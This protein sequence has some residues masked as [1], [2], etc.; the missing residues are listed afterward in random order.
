VPRA[1]APPGAPFPVRKT[2]GTQPVQK[3]R[4]AQSQVAQWES[5]SDDVDEGE[6]EK[7]EEET[8]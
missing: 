6:D 4:F 8:S 2:R 5:D 3:S 7:D 1:R